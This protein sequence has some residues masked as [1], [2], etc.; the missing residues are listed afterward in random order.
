MCIAAF[1]WKAHPIY[2]FLL[3][4]NRDEYYDRPTKALAWWEDGVILGGRDV[5][6]GGTW[7][8]CNLK[9]K[10]AFLTNVREVVDL[11][12]SHTKSR[13]D[14]PV[15]FLR[16]NKSPRDFA[17]E[18]MAEA[19]H[20]GG[21]NL[22]V[23]DICS[24]TMFYITNRPK[25]RGVSVTEVSP[26]IHVLTNASLDSPWPKAQRLQKGFK[27]VL[28]EYGE[29]EIPLE[30]VGKQLMK[31][32]TKDEERNLLPGIY[33]PEREY[34]YSSIF[35]EAEEDLVGRYGTRSTSALAIKNSL[36]VNFYEMC[37]ENDLWKEQTISFKIEKSPTPAHKFYDSV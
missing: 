4:L 30:S 3:F 19:D 2:P 33:A 7:L 29:S 1:Q 5:L 10:I 34:Q 28:E 14:L 13:G 35:V 31:D 6:A 16:S 18:L 15:R 12:S 27:L 23:V 22:I 20:F 8:G 24:M 11:P 36:E 9:G 21:F 32:T 25:D 17:E 26:G 37:L